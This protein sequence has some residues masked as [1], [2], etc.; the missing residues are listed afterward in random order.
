MNQTG[1][2]EQFFTKIIDSLAF[3]SPTGYPQTLSGKCDNELTG[4]H[5]A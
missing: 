5:S 1:E 2:A 4:G 3:I